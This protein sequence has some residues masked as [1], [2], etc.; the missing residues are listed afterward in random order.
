[1][2]RNDEGGVGAITFSKDGDVIDY[3]MVLTGSTRNNGGGR[4]P[5][6]S[7]ISCEDTFGNGTGSGEIYQV[8]PFGARE[9][10]TTTMGMRKG[11][12]NAFAFDTRN[13]THPKFFISESRRR[14]AIQR[15]SPDFT[16]WDSNPWRNLHR[17]GPIDY[18]YLIPTTEGSSAGTFEWIQQHDVAKI[19]AG[20][21]YPDCDEIEVRDNTMFLISTSAKTLR[22][23]DLDRQT[24]STYSMIN[25]LFHDKPEHISQFLDDDDDVDD[26]HG[27]LF[28]PAEGTNQGIHGV[29]RNGEV[30]K[31]IEGPAFPDEP[32]GLAF[33]PDK[34]HMIVTFKVSGIV[35]DI[36]RTDGKPFRGRALDL[37]Y[38]S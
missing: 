33:S 12:F 26:P 19:N 38:F 9:A 22:I 4:T 15:F 13:T 11:S 1:M 30:L 8:D 7:W 34:L 36:T 37:L 27:M 21:V 16:T 3:R 20:N 17:S 32:S 10:K 31:I 5:W 28:F 35:L 24:Y 23:L 29:R 6:N 14:G 18:L 2:D 25:G